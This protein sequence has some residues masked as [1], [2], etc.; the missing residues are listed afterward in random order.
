MMKMKEREFFRL[1]FAISEKARRRLDHAQSNN[2]AFCGSLRYAH[3]FVRLN[4]V[5]SI[6]ANTSIEENTVRFSQH[7]ML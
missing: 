5:F 6:Q 1:A 2:L 3:V 7:L 4:W